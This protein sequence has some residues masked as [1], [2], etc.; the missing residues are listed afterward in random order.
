MAGPVRLH[1]VTVPDMPDAYLIVT[2]ALEPGAVPAIE[3][4]WL[5]DRLAGRYLYER[6]RADRLNVAV[7]SS[8]RRH[9]NMR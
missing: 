3:T 6:A 9:P 1:I 2:T 7:P 8:L 4:Y 5:D